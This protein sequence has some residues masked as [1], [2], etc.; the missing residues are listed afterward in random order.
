MGAAC[1]RQHRPDPG[2]EVQ[3]HEHEA[4][5]IQIGHAYQ[6]PMS[7]AAR[8]ATTTELGPAGLEVGGAESHFE[9]IN[10]QL[11]AKVAQL[12]AANAALQVVVKLSRAT[13]EQHAAAAKIQV[14][15]H[16]KRRRKKRWIFDI[17]HKNDDI[18]HSANCF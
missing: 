8:R 11:L 2:D 13:K 3:Q 12:Q 14:R 6:N 9:F 16:I 1:G 18:F 4:S 5:E 7:A 10:Q 15:T 17:Q